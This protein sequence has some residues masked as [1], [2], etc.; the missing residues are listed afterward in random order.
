[1]WRLTN[2]AVLAGIAKNDSDAFIRFYGD[3]AT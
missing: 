2:Q 3:E 1:V